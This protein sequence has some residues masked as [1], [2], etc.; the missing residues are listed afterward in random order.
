M[1]YDSAQG[2]ITIAVAGDAM[3]TRP[4]RMFREQ[5]FLSLVELLKGADASVVNLEM[6]FHEYEMSWE[7]KDTVSF[8]VSDPSNITEL[9]WMGFN[10]VTTANNHS[11][12]YSEAGFIKT[13]EHCKAKGLKQAGGGP[14]L[15]HARAPA[16]LD[17]AGGRVAVMSATTTFS[18]DSPAG[19]GRP[20][21]P[22]KPGVNALRHNVMHH[23]ESDVFD[24]LHKANRNLGLQEREMA[25]RQ[26]HPVKVD[27]Y[28]PRRE[29][30]F[31]GGKF[32]LAEEYG[33]TTACNRDDLAGISNWIRGAKKAADWPIY[34]VH[35][36]ESGEEGEY[37]G[38]SRIAPPKFLGGICPFQH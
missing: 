23:V 1:I 8:Q 35:C 10:V 18:K 31:M 2:N 5:S 28:D 21:F 3:I 38:G 26:F 6:L 15:D 20:D 13:L 36:H 4:M 37:H 27:E 17:T 19:F 32:S 16:Y 29:L 14:D 30:R 25:G 33:I 24:A 12:D 34:G 22:G 9:Q 7:Y 11:Y